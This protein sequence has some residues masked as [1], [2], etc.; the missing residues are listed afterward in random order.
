M[1]LLKMFQTLHRSPDPDEVSVAVINH[2]RI[3]LRI[4]EAVAFEG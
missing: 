1:V 3:H 4:G 2:L